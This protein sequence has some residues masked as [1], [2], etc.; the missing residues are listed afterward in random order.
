MRKYRKVPSEQ[1]GYAP[2]LFVVQYFDKTVHVWF[3]H[4][5]PRTDAEATALLRDLRGWA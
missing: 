1:A 3:D 5:G 2:G 4:G